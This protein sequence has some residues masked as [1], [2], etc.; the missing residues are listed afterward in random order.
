M[1]GAAMMGNSALLKYFF[2][3]SRNLSR[4]SISM[5]A[6]ST[7]IPVYWILAVYETASFY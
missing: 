2:Q 4:N 6:S 1:P 3:S 5:I 7:K